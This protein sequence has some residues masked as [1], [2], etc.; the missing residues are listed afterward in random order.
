MTEPYKLIVISDTH[1]G[2]VFGLVNPANV[3]EEYKGFAEILFNFYK[4]RITEIGR[5]D[6]VLHLGETTEGPGKKSTLE[7][8]TTD[9]EEQA[10]DASELLLM[11]DCDN[12]SLCYASD[13][14]TG[15]D[16][17]T[18][19]MV[20]DKLKLAGKSANI[21]GVQRLDIRGVKINAKHK[22]GGSATG[23]GGASQAAK[24]AVVDTIRM[25]DKEG[26]ADWYFR[27]HNHDYWHVE[28]SR[29]HVVINPGMKW[30]L[31]DYGKQ[32]DRPYYDMGF[33]QLNIYGP[34]E[35]EYIKHDLKV[36]LPE[37]E[38]VRIE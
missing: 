20:V 28:N 27:G 31:G 6:R 8:Y 11:W 3:R 10:V 25:A 37:E 23:Y 26:P 13:Y 5:V 18:E 34:D 21:Q 17:R 2:D 14:H 19:R 7:L 29:F 16:S 33:R 4:E 1:A 30:G 24:T 12:Y 9:M 36:V 32:L 15:R 38:Y 22:V 35:V